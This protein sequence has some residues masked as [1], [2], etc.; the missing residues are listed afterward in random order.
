M[1]L[2]LIDNILLQPLSMFNNLDNGLEY[3]PKIAVDVVNEL[4]Y[5]NKDGKALMELLF[6]GLPIKKL[7]CQLVLI[8]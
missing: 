2:R 4:F 6:P 7:K 5:N 8:I 1:F 3:N